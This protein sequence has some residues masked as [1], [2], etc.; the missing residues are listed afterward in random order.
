MELHPGQEKHR[1]TEARPTA[2][3]PLRW[4]FH[5]RKHED[6]YEDLVLHSHDLLCIHDLEGRLLSLNPAPARLLGYSVEEILQIP[7][8]ELVVPEFVPQFESYLRQIERT[9]E[10]H[11]LVVVRARSG[12]QRVWEYHNTLRTE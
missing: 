2:S 8:R 6:W 3:D 4:A 10:A 12:Q 9:G 7:M 1:L 5:E 11:G